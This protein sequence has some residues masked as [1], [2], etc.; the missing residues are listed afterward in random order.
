MKI[1]G[2]I[3]TGSIFKGID[4]VV[5][6][7]DLRPTLSHAFI[8]KNQIIATDA[9]C[10]VKINLSFFGLDQESMDYLEGKCIDK[11]TLQKLGAMKTNQQFIINE[12]G[13]CL[14]NKNFKVSVIYPLGKMEEIGKYPNY[15]AVIP[16]EIK[17]QNCTSLNA[18]L[19]LYLD[20][21]FTNCI[22]SEGELK[23]NFHGTNKGVTL[24]SQCGQFKGLLMPRTIN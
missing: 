15:E 1:T 12:Q 16:E 23:M 19:F 6:N 4:K 24:N 11:E 10:L 17:E 7:D 22:Y 14:V 5:A 8:D 21:I 18:K 2:T 20:T 13:F 9:H 3:Y